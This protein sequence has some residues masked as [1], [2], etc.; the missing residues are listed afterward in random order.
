MT[1]PSNPPEALVPEPKL[2]GRPDANRK[3][4]ARMGWAF[5]APALIVIAAVTIFPIVYSVVMSLNNGNVTGN[6]SSLDGFTFSNYNLL[7]HS[8][9]WRDAL[10]FTLYYT[11]VTVVV[12]LIIGTCIALVLERLAAGRGWVMALLLVPSL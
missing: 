4:L 2:R 11:A 5:S 6:G 10:I 1:T 7:L 12:E 8:S 3:R 9:L